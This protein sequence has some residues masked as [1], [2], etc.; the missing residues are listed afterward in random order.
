VASDFAEGLGAGFVGGPVGLAGYAGSKKDQA[1]QKSTTQRDVAEMSQFERNLMG[2]QDTD[3]AA[4][5]GHLEAGPDRDDITRGTQSQRDFAEMLQRYVNGENGPNDKDFSLGSRLAQ[6]AFNPERVAMQ[7]AFTDQETAFARTAARMGRAQ[8]DPILQAKLRTE[9]LR[10]QSS[11]EARQGAFGT[12]YAFTQP[13]QRL[14]YAGQ[15]VNALQGLATQALANRQALLSMGSNLIAGERNWRLQ[16]SGSTST[17]LQ[18]SG[19]GIKG[20]ITG[21]FAGAGT[22]ASIMRGGMAGGAGGGYQAEGGQPQMM[23]APPSQG[24][25]Y[26]QPGALSGYNYSQPSNQFFGYQPTQFSQ[27]TTGYAWR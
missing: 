13:E 22:M 18:E 12:Q 15:R 25:S 27:P 21:A 20:A 24:P 17:G 19:G 3:I 7:Q 14:N 1:T 9:Q 8:T 11:L 5:I 10:Q 26:A 2:R 16:T 4:M 23:A 6:A